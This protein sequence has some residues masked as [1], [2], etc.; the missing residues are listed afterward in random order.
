MATLEGTLA[1]VAPGFE[2]LE[3]TRSYAKAVIGEQL[4]PESLRQ[5]A[6]D[7]LAALL[8]VLRPL[9]RRVARLTTALERGELSMRMRLFA[10][11]RDR[12]FVRSV[13]QQAV[14]AFLGATTGITAVLLLGTSGGPDITP[15]VSLLDV[16][17]F[18]LL[19]VS[20]VLV[21]RGLLTSFHRD[22]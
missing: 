12:R 21:L 8:P 5:A 1:H 19:L 2:I 7:E 3:E 18:N 15:T 4:D 11:E 22:D 20:V 14:L 6:T 13:V 9:P 16:L 10:D 17:G